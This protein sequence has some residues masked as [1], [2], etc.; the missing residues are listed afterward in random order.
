MIYNGQSFAD[1]DSIRRAHAYMGFS[2]DG[3]FRDLRTNS[4]H[5]H[6]TADEIVIEGRLCGRHVREFQGF[7]PTDREV[8]LPYVALYRFG[9]AGRLTSERVVM[10]L[11][12]LRSCTD[13][14]PALTL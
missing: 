1:R 4:D 9:E 12:P 6:F 3:A 13:R 8:E 2:A 10:N 5:E 14:E 11:G 7:A